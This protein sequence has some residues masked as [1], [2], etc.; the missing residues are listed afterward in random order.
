[1]VLDPDFLTVVHWATMALLEYRSDNLF[2]P[3]RVHS[4]LA[5][6]AMSSHH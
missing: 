4:V 1:M 2:D 6:N 5:M 3:N